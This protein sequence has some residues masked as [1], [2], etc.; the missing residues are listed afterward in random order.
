MATDRLSLD[1]EQDDWGDFCVYRL[2]LVL[3]VHCW[4]SRTS[5]M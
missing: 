4:Y 2:H 1:P 5:K 3:A